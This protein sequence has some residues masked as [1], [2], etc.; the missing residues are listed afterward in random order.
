[1][2]GRPIQRREGGASGRGAPAHAETDVGRLLRQVRLLDLVA[3]RNAASLLSGDYE[4]SVRGQG[5]IFHESRKY[6]AGEPA[7]RIDW[8][9]TAR[10]GEPYVKVDLEE[11][12]REVFV[13]L[14]VSPSMHT[15]F[16]HRTKLEYAVE[17]AATLA[18]ST[19]EAGDRLGHVVFADKVLDESRPRG[20]SV[21][22]FRVLRSILSH[23]GRWERVVEVSD[24]RAV[25]HSIQ[26]RRGGRFVVFVISDF[27]DHDLPEDLKY[28]RARHD[29]SLLH[30]Y[31]PVEFAER[32]PAIVRAFSPEGR[33]SAAPLRPGATGDLA[34]MS[35]FLGQEAGRYGI[36]VKSFS[37]ARPVGE[38][39]GEFFHLRCCQA[40]R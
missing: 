17:L 3:R 16:Q 24:P 1:M 2:K 10:L 13:A 22:L 7:R 4:T 39:L 31:D 35:R 36:A 6:V 27:I 20:G 18:A 15:G 25:V 11:R 12:Q 37:T 8:N 9:V 21:Q 30:I 40:I 34:E 33:P 5:L 14:D 26:S 28:F 29:V 38:A 32:G 19:I 23:V